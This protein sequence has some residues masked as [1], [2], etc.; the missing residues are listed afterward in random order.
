LITPTFAG[1]ASRAEHASIALT[2]LRSGMPSISGGDARDSKRHPAQFPLV[3][4]L[5]GAGRK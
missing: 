4:E 5:S 2:A 1:N 3:R